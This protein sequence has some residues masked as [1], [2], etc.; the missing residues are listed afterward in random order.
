MYVSKMGVSTPVIRTL[1]AVVV[2]GFV[3]TA[4]LALSRR[5]AHACA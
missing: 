3:L 1:F 5:E 2:T 4:A